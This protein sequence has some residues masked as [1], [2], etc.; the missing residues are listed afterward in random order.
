[1]QRLNAAIRASLASPDV[2]ESFAAVY[3]EPHPT[4]P[5]QLAAQLKTETQFWGNLVKTV[6]YTPEG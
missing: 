6:G 4:T 5:Q 3:M 2:V 1:M